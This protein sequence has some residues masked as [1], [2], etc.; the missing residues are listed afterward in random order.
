MLGSYF[1][2]QSSECAAGTWIST[3]GARCGN[4]DGLWMIGLVCA[5][6]STLL[7]A[8]LG[9]FVVTRMRLQARRQQERAAGRSPE[10][11]QL[12]EQTQ[13]FLSSFPKFRY[14]GKKL[15]TPSGPLHESMRPEADERGAAA[16]DAD[17]DA[18]TCSIC[19]VSCSDGL[20]G[21]QLHMLA[22]L[23]PRAQQHVQ[24]VARFCEQSS[25]HGA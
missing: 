14:N 13:R 3:S 5:T 25:K 12:R 8:G 4:G 22:H 19:L 10:Q 21:A 9:G 2:P 1:R 7:V 24:C 17:E 20:V 16:S 11:V 6:G 18:P 23:P 15:P